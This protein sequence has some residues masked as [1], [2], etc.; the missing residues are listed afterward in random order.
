MDKLIFPSDYSLGELTIWKGE[1][2]VRIIPQAQG[3]VPVDDDEWVILRANQETC[4]KMERLREIPPN[5]LRGFWIEDLD[6]AGC[7][8]SELSRMS[9]LELVG[10][11]RVRITPLQF[12]QM[13]DLTE[14]RRLDLNHTIPILTLDWMHRMQRVEKVALHY[15][16]IGDEQLRTLP[17]LGIQSLILCGTRISDRSIPKLAS[18]QSLKYLDLCEKRITEEGRS[19]LAQ[20]LPNCF[21][22]FAAP[23]RSG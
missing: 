6:I 23:G 7:D 2:A 19:R 1:D 8:L 12:K 22:R 9:G 11:S 17:Q 15:A 21:I 10:L 16:D 13:A 4:D 18:L 20:F 14:L 5:V 3:V